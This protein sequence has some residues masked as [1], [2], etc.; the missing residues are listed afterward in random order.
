MNAVNCSMDKL[1]C[2]PKR[3]ADVT[4]ITVA[5]G[6]SCVF[7]PTNPKTAFNKVMSASVNGVNAFGVAFG[8]FDWLINRDTNRT[9]K[10]ITINNIVACVCRGV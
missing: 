6:L 1:D 8:A 7:N 10:M 2:V 5:R 3:I 9:T 4:I